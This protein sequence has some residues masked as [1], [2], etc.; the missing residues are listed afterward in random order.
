MHMVGACDW[1]GGRRRKGKEGGG[2]GVSEFVVEGGGGGW[3]QM[4]IV[5]ILQRL[6]DESELSKVDLIS[7]IEIQLSRI[8]GEHLTS[9]IITNTSTVA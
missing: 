4:Y 9:N 5:L 8:I 7:E 3:G 2:E 1:R 6:T